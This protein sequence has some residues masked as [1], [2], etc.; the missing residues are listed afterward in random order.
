MF[1]VFKKNYIKFTIKNGKWN[2]TYSD[3]LTLLNFFQ[4]L[5]NNVIGKLLIYLMMDKADD[6]LFSQFLI[7]LADKIDEINLITEKPDPRLRKA[8]AI[9]GRRANNVNRMGTS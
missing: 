2:I 6:K 5:I 9:Y 3:S 1:K 8:G 7:K 4:D